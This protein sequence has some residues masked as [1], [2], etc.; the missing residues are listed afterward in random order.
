MKR[1]FN[2]LNA[3]PKPKIVK[4]K[5]IL[6]G[7]EKKEISADYI[8]VLSLEMSEEGVYIQA[9]E[10]GNADIHA[11]VKYAL[12][13]EVAK[14]LGIHPEV[15]INAVKREVEAGRFGI[16]VNDLCPDCQEVEK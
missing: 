12:V 2:Q 6:L 4:P 15:L 13:M 1:L 8:L 7:Q 11:G 10:E 16:P 9:H 14:G 5:V 3:I